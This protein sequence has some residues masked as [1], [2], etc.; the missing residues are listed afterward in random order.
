MSINNGW[1]SDY[2]SKL[3]KY[4]L[5]SPQKPETNIIEIL[6]RMDNNVCCFKI[7]YYLAFVCIILPNFHPNSAGVGVSF[8]I[9]TK[10]QNS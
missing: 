8:I 7:N 9:Q 6:Y 1:E 4:S 5:Q 2:F 10:I 3:R